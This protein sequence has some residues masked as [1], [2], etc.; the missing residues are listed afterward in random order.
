MSAKL[1]LLITLLLTGCRLGDATGPGSSVPHIYHIGEIDTPGFAFAVDAAGG[2]AYVADGFG[3]LRIINIETPH[4]PTHINHYEDQ[5]IY[6]DVKYSGGDY[7][8][9]AAGDAGFKVI[10]VKSPFGP[11]LVGEF[12]TVNAFGLDYAGHYVYLADDTGGV[13]ILDVSNPFHITQISNFNVSGQNVNNVRLAWPYLYVSS[14]YG[15]SIV[16]IENPFSP[17]EIHYQTLSNVYDMEVSGHL[18]YVAFEG[19]LRIYDI[20]QPN[21]PQELGFAHL[22]ATARSVQVRGEFAYLALGRSGLSIVRI[23]NPSLPFEIAYYAPAAGEM[24]DVTLYGRYLLVANGGVG[25]LI[26]EFWPGY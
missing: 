22:P 3:G 1:L 15:F 2:N 18:L 21:N 7:A 19:G 20:S 16:N 11:E 9:I 24:S 13:R 12:T 25:L 10:D 23:S 6:Y 5:G 4:F 14:R 26:L 8:Y 17:I